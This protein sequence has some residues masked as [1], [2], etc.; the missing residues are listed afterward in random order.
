M[1]NSRV[2]AEVASRGRGLRRPQCQR[3]EPGHHDPGRG[4]TGRK[5]LASGVSHR[6]GFHPTLA[7]SAGPRLGHARLQGG[8]S[9]RAPEACAKSRSS[10]TRTKKVPRCNKGLAAVSSAAIGGVVMHVARAVCC[11]EAGCRAGTMGALRDSI[12]GGKRRA[13]APG[14]SSGA[15]CAV[16]RMREGRGRA[17]TGGAF[18]RAGRWAARREECRSVHQGFDATA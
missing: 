11:A 16:K 6:R 18:R 7:A 1:Q 15:F 10:T 4:Q 14:W 13:P 12:S 8:L 2:M 17:P 3:K 5:S 9:P